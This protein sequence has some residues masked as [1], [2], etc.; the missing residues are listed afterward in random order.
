[1]AEGVR[2][3]LRRNAASHPDLAHSGGSGM[4]GVLAE[5]ADNPEQARHHCTTP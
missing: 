5:A 3:I 2:P 4:M 1:M